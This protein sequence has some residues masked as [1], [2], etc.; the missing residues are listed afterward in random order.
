MLPHGRG[1]RRAVRQVWDQP[2][3]AAERR[4]WAAQFTWER[5]AGMLRNVIQELQ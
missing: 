3:D 1:V 2:G 5:S 4:A